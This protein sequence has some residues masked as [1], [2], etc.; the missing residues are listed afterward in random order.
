MLKNITCIY[1]QQ[2]KIFYGRMLNVN[3]IKRKPRYWKADKQTSDF[4]KNMGLSSFILYA[5]DK[6]IEKSFINR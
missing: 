5:I 4:E 2:E 1:I 3:F 6:M